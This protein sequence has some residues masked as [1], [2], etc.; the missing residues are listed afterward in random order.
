IAEGARA[1]SRSPSRGWRRPSSRPTAT[2]RQGR[3]SAESPNKKRDFRRLWIERINAGVRQHGMP[4]S[5]FVNK[6]RKADV[7]L[8][9]KV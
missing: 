2:E 4:Y 6:A 3:A 5:V 7:E 1:F 9:R 8:N